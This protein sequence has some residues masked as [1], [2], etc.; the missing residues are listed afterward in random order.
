VSQYLITLE[1]TEDG[2]GVEVPDLAIATFGDTIEAAMRAASEAIRINL[3][4]YEE[5]GMPVP[6]REPV[7]RH[8]ENPDNRG[9]LFAYVDVADSA[10][11]A[12]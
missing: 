10:D 5:L 9:L 4:A 2:F 1:A 12:A 3:D 8:L 7:Q 11:K 6:P